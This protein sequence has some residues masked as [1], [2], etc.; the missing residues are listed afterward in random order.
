[1]IKVRALHFAYAETPTLH[2]LSFDIAEGS[3]FGFLG[4]SGAGKSTTQR[5]LTRLLRNYDGDLWVMNKPLQ[6]W[7]KHYYEHIGVY[8]ELPNHYLKLTA[9]ENLSYFKR[10]YST[11]TLAAEEVLEKVGLGEHKDKRVSAFSK[12]MRNRL[13]L[14]RTLLHRPRV[15][16]LDEPTAGLDP[17]NAAMVKDIIRA[18]QAD[19]VTVFLTT[20]NMQVA[21]ELCD[22]VAF[23]VDGQIRLIDTPHTLKLQHGRRVVRVK[24][25]QQCREFPLAGIGENQPFMQMLRDE[26][27]ETI[28][29]QETTLEDIFIKVTGQSLQ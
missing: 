16:F 3:I 29:T 19:G 27:I 4:P 22:T 15:L 26:S 8:F 18:Q 12:G 6:D 2:N 25:S 10:L 7:D 9:L 5:I 14:A 20:H 13:T 17:N 21:D 1:M 28:H 11:P 23:L 24:T